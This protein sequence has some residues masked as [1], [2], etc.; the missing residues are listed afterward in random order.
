VPQRLDG[1]RTLAQQ[2]QTLVR[3]SIR[4]T[5]ATH[6]QLL[7]VGASWTGAGRGTSPVGDPADDPFDQLRKQSDVPVIIDNSINLSAIGERWRGLATGVSD[8]AFVSV[9]AGVGVGIVVSDE[10]V[11]GAHLAAGDLA[12]LPESLPSPGNRRR[13]QPVGAMDASALLGYAQGLRWKDGPPDAIGDIFARLDNE[14]SAR[15]VIEA[16]AARIA[17][18]IATICAVLDPELVVLGGGIGSFPQLL[19]PVREATGTLMTHPVR[20]ESSLLRDQAALYGALAA[21]LRD[22][23]DQLFRRGT[24]LLPISR[25]STG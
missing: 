20:I 2:V 6:S 8:F 11:R 22:A 25:R 15:R 18:G 12:N 10:L 16:Q 7:A 1:S 4:T 19:E 14:P 21:A 9:G 23:H 13:P 5:G 3:E 17:F 24:G